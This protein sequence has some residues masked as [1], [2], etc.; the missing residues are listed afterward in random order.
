M[1]AM[2]TSALLEVA[3]RVKEY[4]KLVNKY[5]GSTYQFDNIEVVNA[6]N[7]DADADGDE[8]MSASK[9]LF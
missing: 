9:M 7:R 5:N 6:G 8:G 2:L 1:M 3:I 4:D